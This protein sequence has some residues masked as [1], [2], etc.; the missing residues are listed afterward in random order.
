[1]NRSPEQRRAMVQ[2]QDLPQLDGFKLPSPSVMADRVRLRSP[3]S[4]VPPSLDPGPHQED[5]SQ[6]AQQR[7]PGKVLVCAACGRP[8]TR[9]EARTIINGNHVH[10]FCNP[11]GVVFEVGCFSLAAGLRP[12]GGVYEEFS[13]FPGHAWQIMHCGRC[14]DHLGWRF[15]TRSGTG[16]YGLLPAK[17]REQTEE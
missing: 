12:Q 10:V 9:P 15:T 16:F 17:L 8:V 14:N 3:G 1:M 11:H 7:R 5:G 2:H 4:R 6:N 13:W